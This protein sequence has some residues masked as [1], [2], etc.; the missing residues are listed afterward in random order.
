MKTHHSSSSISTK[1]YKG[2]YQDGNKYYAMIKNGGKLICMGPFSTA[3]DA[4]IGY[5]CGLVGSNKPSSCYNFP[6]F[7]IE[8]EEDEEEEEE[9]ED[10]DE[11]VWL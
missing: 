1:N 6:P 11:P 7:E 9:E 5:D 3:R 2:L 8:E 10:D 4:A